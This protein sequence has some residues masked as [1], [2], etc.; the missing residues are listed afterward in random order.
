VGTSALVGLA[1]ARGIGLRIGGNQVERPGPAGKS[2]DA[3]GRAGIILATLLWEPGTYVGS[4]GAKH[5]LPFSAPSL[6][7]RR[8][9][10]TFFRLIPQTSSRYGQASL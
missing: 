3:G 10:S 8:P 9:P 2:R 7:R 1:V 6:N 4:A 5:L